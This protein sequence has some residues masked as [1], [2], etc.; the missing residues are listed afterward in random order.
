MLKSQNMSFAVEGS[1]AVMRK[2]SCS[3]KTNNKQKP[4]LGT[5]DSSFLVVKDVVN[6]LQ[7]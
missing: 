6:N 2:F 7:Q 1:S 4:N 3:T 5:K